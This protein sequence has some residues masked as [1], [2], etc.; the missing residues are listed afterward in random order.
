MLQNF[1]VQFCIHYNN[2]GFFKMKKICVTCVKNTKI[3]M[4]KNGEMKCHWK[5]K[6]RGTKDNSKKRCENE[7][8]FFCSL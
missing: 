3:V 6:A 4:M 2:L 7:G 1:S 8:L 5:K